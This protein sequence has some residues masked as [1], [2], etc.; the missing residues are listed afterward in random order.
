MSDREAQAE[1][2]ESLQAIYGDDCAVEAEAGV[3]EVRPGPL[4]RAWSRRASRAGRRGRRAA[5]VAGALAAPPLSR[6]SA[7]VSALPPAPA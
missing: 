7:A 2:F 6:P 4:A 5:R 3:V 1:E